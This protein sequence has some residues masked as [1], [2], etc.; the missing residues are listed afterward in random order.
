FPLDLHLCLSH[1]SWFGPGSLLHAV[2]ALLVFLFGMKP[3][4]MAFVPYV[5]I[6]EAS[7]IFLNINYWLD[8]TGNSGTTL[9]AIN[10]TFLL[11]LFFLTRCVE[12]VF[13]AAKMYCE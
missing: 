1:Y 2:S 3:F 10:E 8:K 12:G 11:A 9:Q 4:L 7:T 13:I 5:L 6:W